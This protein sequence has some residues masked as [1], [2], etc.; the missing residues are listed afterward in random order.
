MIHVIC[1][2][3][4][5]VENVYLITLGLNIK[6]GGAVGGRFN[7]ILAA[8]G[9]S[10]ARRS[11]GGKSIIGSSSTMFSSSWN[12]TETRIEIQSTILT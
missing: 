6:P 2:G 9:T 7:R 8:K 3:A 12:E 5:I 4:E 11:T 1:K 10:D